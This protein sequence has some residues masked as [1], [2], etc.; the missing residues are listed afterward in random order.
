MKEADYKYKGGKWKEYVFDDEDNDL[1]FI[2]EAYEFEE[3]LKVSVSERKGSCIRE[4]FDSFK[5]AVKKAVELLGKFEVIYLIIVPK[6]TDPDELLPTP[7]KVRFKF[8]GEVTGKSYFAY[9]ILPN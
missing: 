8:C 3:D 7:E 4:T 5:E 6:N 1:D 2:V 9:I